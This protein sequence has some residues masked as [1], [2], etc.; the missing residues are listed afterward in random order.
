MA[1]NAILILPIIISLSM[2]FSPVI[3]QNE[4]YNLHIEK[5]ITTQKYNA[6]F[7]KDSIS[8]NNYSFKECL[9]LL[10]DKE[11]KII[12]FDDSFMAMGL[13]LLKAEI[14]LNID[15]KNKNS[16]NEIVN[17]VLTNKQN[18][19]NELQN[20]YN[21]TLVN[22]NKMKTQLK[23]FIKDSLKFKKI[24]T[25]LGGG[26]TEKFYNV[27]TISVKNGS[28]SN[29]ARGLNKAYK[30]SNIFF[31]EINDTQCFSIEINKIPLDKLSSYLENKYGLSLIEENKMAEIIKVIFQ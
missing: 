15:Y 7:S 2:A 29:L 17:T 16:E 19:L 6:S 14:L 8:I 5:V 28:I 11:E 23:L 31:A 10:L 4:E 30:K 27:N 26:K 1:G 13:P 9:S 3:I 25:V 22:Q 12:E 21:F 20:V 18:I 24:S